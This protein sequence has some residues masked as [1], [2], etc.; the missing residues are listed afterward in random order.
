MPLIRM[1][2]GG[3][4][5]VAVLLMMESLYFGT[6]LRK[7]SERTLGLG[8]YGLPAAQR[9]AYRRGL[10][11]KALVL[12]PFLGLI[13]LL[14]K[15]DFRQATFVFRGVGGPHGTTSPASFARGADWQPRPSDIVVATQMKCGTTWMQHLVYQVLTRGGGN[16]VESGQALYAV[17]PWLEGLRS[18]SMDQAPLV[19]DERPSR[20]V[21]THF[22]ASLCPWSP[23]ARYIYVARHPLS[24]FA[25]TVDFVAGNAGT[26]AP[27]IATFERWF[28]D[29]AL[30]WWGTWPDHV[31]GWWDRA[32]AHDNVLFVFF[33]DMKAD[34]PAVTRRVA[35]FLGTRPL[36]ETELAETVRKCSFAYMQANQAAFEMHPPQ[37]LQVDA[38]MFVKGSADRYQ[39]VPEDV[40]GRLA[41]W[42]AAEMEGSSFP[43]AAR[44]PD[45]VRG[46]AA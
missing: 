41:A 44:Y 9:A 39:D 37:L 10:R 24:C 7:E 30:M 6:V 4:A 35:A 2:L 20:I 38:E 25:S 13:G 8:Y 45:V 43:L 36:S 15:L 3:L 31:K 46:S 11:W 23:D 19:G 16:L 17:S 33:E 27:P 14:T 22:P 18:V 26:M 34:L 29:P 21:K 12:R 32:A 40:R 28:R 1:V 42:V 5:V